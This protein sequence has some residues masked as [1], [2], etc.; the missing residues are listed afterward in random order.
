[1]FDSTYKLPLLPNIT[2]IVKTLCVC[3]YVCVC[4]CLCQN[5]PFRDSRHSTKNHLDVGKMVFLIYE[6]L[7]NYY[8]IGSRERTKTLRTTFRMPHDILFQFRFFL[9]SF[10]G[11]SRETVILYSQSFLCFTAQLVNI[12]NSGA[13]L[14]NALV[15]S[16]SG[17]HIC[18]FNQ[19]YKSGKIISQASVLMIEYLGGVSFELWMVKLLKYFFYFDILISVVAEIVKC[20]AYVVKRLIIL[21]GLLTLRQEMF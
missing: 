4:V 11:L 15:T 6:I 20:Y 16:K 10:S 2:L 12:N 7:Q 8:N 14:L 21:K 17:G 3:V 1:M 19:H 13:P 18:F 9:F 5:I